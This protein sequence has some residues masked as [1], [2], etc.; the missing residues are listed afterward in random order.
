M[1]LLVN[2]F[3]L[4]PGLEPA[5]FFAVWSEFASHLIGEGLAERV[6]P[7][8]QRQKPSGYDTDE[9]RSHSFIALIEFRDTDQADLAWDHLESRKGDAAKAHVAVLA[10]V[11]DAVFTYWGES[12]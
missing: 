1:R 9:D 3:D 4:K 11:R 5:H 6:S 12:D 10:S 2:Q 8:M 7:P